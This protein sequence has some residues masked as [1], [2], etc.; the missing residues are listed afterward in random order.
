LHTINSNFELWLAMGGYNSVDISNGE[1][2]DSE[3]S[4]LAVVEF[5]N[6]IV[7]LPQNSNP[8]D[9]YIVSQ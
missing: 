6:K 5:M 2:T 1:I 7:I 8:E 9:K 4:H 3:S